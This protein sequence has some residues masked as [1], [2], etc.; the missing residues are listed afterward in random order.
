[1]TEEFLKGVYGL[2]DPKALRDHYD[3]WSHSYDDD[4]RQ[5]G[6]ATPTRVAQALKDA[7]G[8]GPVLD[9][10]CGTG[11]SGAALHAAGFDRI[12]G[13]DVSAE[14]L[15]RAA[16]KGIYRRVIHVRPDDDL[17]VQ[18]GDYAAIVATGVIG[19]GAAPLSVFDALLAVL[20]TGALLAF[21]FN[22]HTLEDPDYEA[23]V[24]AACEDGSLR[25]I[26]REAGPH[27]PQEGIGAV[28][29]VAERTR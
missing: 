29:Y 12:D 4:L 28:V 11:L 27:L 18:R 21:S 3:R 24:T 8:S 20:G 14:M 7:G 16:D 19:A 25:L 17:P 13:L 5:A 15:E 23:R 26:S 10:G 6:Y 1:M 22:D 9:F 2:T